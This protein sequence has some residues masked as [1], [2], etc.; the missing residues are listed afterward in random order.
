MDALTSK[1]ITTGTTTGT[2]TR[3]ANSAIQRPVSRDQQLRD[4][5]NLVDIAI[6]D[7]Y[8]YNANKEPIQ[9]LGNV[10]LSQAYSAKLRGELETAKKIYVALL[11][12]AITLFQNK[13]SDVPE[14]FVNEVKTQLKDIHSEVGQVKTQLEDIHSEAKLLDQIFS[15]YPKYTLY[16]LDPKMLHSM[17]LSILIASA[18]QAGRKAASCLYGDILYLS[19]NHLKAA[20]YYEKSAAQE[21]SPAKHRVRNVCLKNRP[22]W[23]HA[24]HTEGIDC[25][26]WFDKENLTLAYQQGDPMAI[27]K[28]GVLHLVGDPDNGYPKNP[29]FAIQQLNKA[30]KDTMGAEE[31]VD[32]GKNLEAQHLQTLRKFADN[33]SPDCCDLSK[34]GSAKLCYQ[35]AAAHGNKEA[36]SLLA[37]LEANPEK[38]EVPS[39]TRPSEEELFTG[40]EIKARLLLEQANKLITSGNTKAGQEIVEELMAMAYQLELEELSAPGLLKDQHRNQNVQRKMYLISLTERAEKGDIEVLHILEEG[41]ALE[42]AYAASLT[43]TIPQIM[44]FDDQQKARLHYQ[45]AAAYGNQEAEIRGLKMDA[46]K[47]DNNAQYLLGLMGK[48]GEISRSLPQD[49]QQLNDPAIATSNIAEAA[50]AGHK[51]ARSFLNQNGGTGSRDAGSSSSS[52]IKNRQ[53]DSPQIL[54]LNPD[55]TKPPGT[56]EDPFSFL[57]NLFNNES[58]T[59]PPIPTKAAPPQI[60]P[61]SRGTKAFLASPQANDSPDANTL[62]SSF[63]NLWNSETQTKPLT[64]AKAAP[65]QI[66]PETP[67]TKGTLVFK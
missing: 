46:G 13:M 57:T 66:A 43:Q 59:T 61:E 20:R 50:K 36:E 14:A 52:T 16:T 40:L 35:I 41:K 42:A 38:V 10:L 23:L 55:S 4:F 26:P 64:T 12:A 22:Y 47:G 28:V 56:R 34:L 53:S 32:L 65:P 31:I 51:A 19:S 60:V 2:T 3:I 30:A 17:D 7:C 18:N 67:D 37:K 27:A 58:D 29:S 9:K 62:W 63:V 39:G 48:K 8:S 25:N 5:K 49:L 54:P 33:L 6:N 44:E 45:I 11:E 15:H 1:V 24:K 21:F